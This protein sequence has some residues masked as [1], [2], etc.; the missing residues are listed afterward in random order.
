MFRVY[1]WQLLSVLHSGVRLSTVL[2]SRMPSPA[3][4]TKA[5][6]QAMDIVRYDSVAK[7]GEIAA[8]LIR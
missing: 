1:F 2:C 5:L 3:S 6:Q 7:L 8:V 4:G